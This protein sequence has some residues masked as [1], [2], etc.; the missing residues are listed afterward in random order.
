VT[1]LIVL[2]GAVGLA[3]ALAPGAAVPAGGCAHAWNVRKSAIAQPR[4]VA[5]NMLISVPTPCRI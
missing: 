4:F 2:S 1:F 5:D 3:A